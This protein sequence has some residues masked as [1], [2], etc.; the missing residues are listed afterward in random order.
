MLAS[1]TVTLFASYV[2][3]GDSLSLDVV[4]DRVA[5]VA[6][7]AGRPGGVRLRIELC[8][9]IRSIRH[10]VGSPDPMAYIPLGAEREVVV[11]NFL[12]VSLL[13]FGAINKCN[14]L[15]L[16]SHQRIGLR[17][18]GKDDLRV[19]LRVGDNVSHPRLAPALVHCR[20]AGLTGS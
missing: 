12:K 14:V 7:G 1:R 16:E 20:M 8:P 13:P 9:P 3:F 4:V 15:F 19:H 5:A 2:P 18:I 6:Q 10:V 11:T 17:E